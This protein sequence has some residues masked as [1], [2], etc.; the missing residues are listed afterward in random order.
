MRLKTIIVPDV[1]HNVIRLNSI[2]QE[3]ADNRVFL[4]DWF[5]DFGDHPSHAVATAKRLEQLM[6]D[7]TNKFLYGNHD[8]HYAFPLARATRCSGFT[9]EKLRA[10]APYAEGIRGRF[11]LSVEVEGWRL[12]HAGFHPVYI[13]IDP[14][15]SLDYLMADPTHIPVLFKAGQARGGDSKVGGCTWLDW[16]WEF[17]DTPG[18]KQIVGH[19]PGEQVRKIGESYCLDT[20]L[21]HYGVIENGEFSWHH[22]REK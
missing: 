8:V 12:S 21:R 17:K 2:L 3:E 18:I 9:E 7:P 11:R 20:H 16:N 10:L 13:G 14:D 5:D 15:T 4:G 1:H 19:T 22:T 6:L